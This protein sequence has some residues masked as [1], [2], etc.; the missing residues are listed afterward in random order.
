MDQP[1]FALGKLIQWN[2]PE[3]P[4]KDKYV[5]MFGGLHIEI[6]AFKALGEF[7]DGSGWVK[8]L[9]NAD[10]ASSGTAE[11]FVKVSHL[12][13]KQ[14]EYMRLQLLPYMFSNSQH[15]MTTKQLYQLPNHA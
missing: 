14:D 7:L 4:G 10:T 8:A 6:A 12:S 1:L 15:M 2:T 9:L 5:A 11:S 3:T 13:K